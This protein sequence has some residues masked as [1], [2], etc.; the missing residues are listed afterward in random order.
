MNEERKLITD[1]E[2]RKIEAVKEELRRSEDH[3]DKLILKSTEDFLRRDGMTMEEKLMDMSRDDSPYKDSA[4][5]QHF[6]SIK[7]IRALRGSIYIEIDE[8]DSYKATRLR[9]LR[10]LGPLV[11]PEELK[12]YIAEHMNTSRLLSVPK[13]L[14]NLKLLAYMVRKAPHL[15]GEGTGG[16][17]VKDIL[18]ESRA[19]IKEAI[20]YLK[21]NRDTMPASLYEVLTQKELDVTNK[22]EFVTYIGDDW[23]KEL[24]D[25]ERATTG[26]NLL[27]T[28]NFK[29]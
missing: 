12:T 13:F 21:K 19:A 27:L 11:S 26:I 17:T 3:D 18:E 1:E 22:A 20:D 6:S 28:K 29:K 23:E 4:M 8:H 15:F 5:Q 14:K 16:G 2:R 9:A 10:T 7:R 24:V 25:K